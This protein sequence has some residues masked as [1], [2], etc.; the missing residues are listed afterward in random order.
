MG[1]FSDIQKSKGHTYHDDETSIK[2]SLIQ[3][4]KAFLI[5][6]TVVPL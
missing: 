1:G 4:L 2:L 5:L 3:L 6:V